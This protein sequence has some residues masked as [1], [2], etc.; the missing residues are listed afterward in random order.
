MQSIK[1]KAYSLLARRSYFSKQL[2]HK[3]LEKGYPQEEI[4]NLI[5]ELTRRGWLNDLELAKRYCEQQQR[6]GYGPKLIALKLREKA[7]PI[8]ISLE[9]S[10]EAAIALVRK[11]YMPLQR[12][13]VIRALLRRGFSFELINKVLSHISKE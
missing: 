5:D 6:R 7:G 2:K 1:A 4:K 11:R 12:E 10:E 8:D 13:K 3:L 9:E